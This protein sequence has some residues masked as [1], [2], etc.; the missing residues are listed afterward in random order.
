MSELKQAVIIG[1]LGRTQDRF[2]EYNEPLTTEQKL[3][4]VTKIDGFSGVEIVYPYETLDPA[5]TQALMSKY[6]LEYAA[7]NVNIKKEAEWVGGALTRRPDDV[8]QRAVDMIKRA[9][10][11]AKAVGAPHV[12]CC[13]LNDG[14]DILFQI[15]Y[16]EAWKNLVDAFAEAADYMPEVPLFLEPKYS[17][18]RV[19]CQID[20]TAKGLLLLKDIACPNTGITL[21]MGHSLQSQENPAQA[22]SLIYE[23]GF[24]A[25]IHTNDND[26][27]ADW[28][29][30]GASRHFLHYVELMFW[31]QEYGYNKFF[32]T[33]AS[34]RIFDVVDF[35]TTHSQVTQ[36]IHKLA[37]SLNH[38]EIKA[39]M[40]S[41]DYSALMKMVN[42]AIYRV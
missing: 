41:E 32:T 40:Q 10:D 11:F 18:T 36:G 34:P 13:P 37:E 31:A 25:Y 16:K 22:L 1:F 5:E 20:S 2:S 27:K 9:K 23:N 6:N 30:M 7:I 26:T 42:T 14:Y 24:D 19:H 35:F 28:D 38:A 12:T 29:L 8:R 3:E 33:D 17:E 4:T 15:D 21:D 39:M